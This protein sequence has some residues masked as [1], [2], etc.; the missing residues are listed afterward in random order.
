MGPTDWT[1]AVLPDGREVEFVYA[2]YAERADDD[3]ADKVPVDVHLTIDG[4]LQSVRVYLRMA[5]VQAAA[6]AAGGR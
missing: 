3:P 1:H 6:L 4:H 2:T 5:D